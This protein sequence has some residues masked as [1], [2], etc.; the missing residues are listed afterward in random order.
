MASSC[1][2]KSHSYQGRYMRLTC[3]QTKNIASNTSTVS[4]EL[5]VLGGDSNYYTTGPTTVVIGGETVYYKAKTAWDT[6]KFPAAEGSVSG[7]TTVKHDSN[8]DASITVSIKT[9]IYTGVLKTSKITWTLDHIDRFATIESAPNFNDE[10]NP[11][12]TYSNPA[13][14]NVSSLQACIASSDGNT[15]YV[16]YRDISKSGDQYTFELTDT[17]RNTLRA[18]TTNANSM[19]VKFYVRSTIGSNTD[20]D[21][22]AKTF[23]IKNPLPTISPSIKDV[24][25]KTIELTGDSNILVKYYSDASVA[26]GAK[27]VKAASLVKQSVACGNSMLE[28]DGTF[29]AVETDKFVFSATD[30]RGNTNALILTP[31]FVDYVPVSCVLGHSIPDASG[32]MTVKA[33]GNC[34][35]GSFGKT[36]NSVKAYYRYKPSGGEFGEWS[37]MTVTLG[38]NAFDAAAVLSGLDYQTSYVFQAYAEDALEKV[39]STEKTVKAMP[40]FCWGENHFTFNTPVDVQGVPLPLVGYPVKSVVVRFDDVSPASLFGGTWTRLESVFLWAAP[41]DSALGE[42]DGEATHQLTVDEMPSHNHVLSNG[43]IVY[44]NGGAKKLDSSGNSTAA[45]LN[46]NYGY[47]TKSTGGSAAHNNMPPYITVAIWVR[48][49]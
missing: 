15:V 2:L 37:E 1:T 43:T 35:V 40:V 11:T 14:S 5:E 12:I 21:S 19:S 22:V 47:T 18:A 8:G 44:V 42:I 29:Q 27:A 9:N 28:A 32:K 3:K 46:T 45:D 16:P 24:N 23:S 49:E 13:G 20:Q 31:D 25:E 17:E 39:E 4:W 7:K 30:S 10:E 26:I 6:K 48:I 38:E 33:Y 34:F 36:S 41:A